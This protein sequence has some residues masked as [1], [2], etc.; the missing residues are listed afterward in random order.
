MTN[1]RV[2]REDI[3]PGQTC[4]RCGYDNGQIGEI[5]PLVAYF[6]NVWG[7][8][9]FGLILLP[10]FALMS[11]NW[12]N[13]ILQPIASIMVAGP[14]S[15]LVTAIIAFYMYSL[16]NQIHHYSLTRKFRKN[17][18]RSVAL[19][20]LTFFVIAILF[21]FFLAFAIVDKDSLVGPKGYGEMQVEGLLVYGSTAH[22]F[23]K[24]TMTGVVLFTF[25]FL[26]LSAGMMAAYLYGHYM[27]SHLPNPLYMNEALLIKVVLGTVKQQMGEGAL[28]SMTGMDR[29]E[30]A[31][32][33][34][35]LASEEKLTTQGGD[36]VQKGKTWSVKA[37]CWGRVNNIE[38]KG[39]R[40]IKV[41]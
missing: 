37:D 18:G 26:G 25:V 17:P 3:K 6:G 24:L 8:L 29:L 12:V 27:E 23:L 31:G 16:R 28:I 32:I 11:F 22:M 40:L 33:S 7:I 4:P 35:D 9:S 39:L 38:E 41:S 30:D 20:A 1:C 34:L 19:W 21:V 10:L 14:I 5:S 2:C 15:L 36:T 13:S